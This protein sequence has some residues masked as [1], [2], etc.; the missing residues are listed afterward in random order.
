MTSSHKLR[1]LVGSLVLLMMAAPAARAQFAVIDAASIARLVQQAQTLSQQ[2]QAA[3]AQIL[4]AQS[5]YQS[6][7][8]SR[9]MQQ[10]L[11]GVQ[12]NYLPS[13]WSQLNAA[14]QATGP[15]SGA[16]S[17]DIRVATSSN[18]VLSASQI[19]ALPA[20]GQ[21]QI[22]NARGAVA[23]QQAV[24]QEALANSSG[25]FASI[26]QLITT[27]GSTTD[28]KGI[29][30][31]HARIGAEQGML[32]NEQTKL[33]VLYQLAQSQSAVVAQQAREQI[34]A[35]HGSFASRFQPVPR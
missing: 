25:R 18:A 24:A 9:G 29:L 12:R 30:E 11:S 20:G 28:Q 14:M 34:I 19:A 32:Q 2:L 21:S 26:Q 3:R 10:L 23:L 33:Q 8:G 17:Q 22:A 35:G 27:I 6:T 7:T 13:N 5:L 4:Q 15:A 31:L 16:L 1:L